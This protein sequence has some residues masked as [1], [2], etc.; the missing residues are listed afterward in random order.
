MKP[1]TLYKRRDNGKRRRAIKNW[2][3]I[4]GNKACFYNVT[5]KPKFADCFRYLWI[6]ICGAIAPQ[7]NIYIN[8]IGLAKIFIRQQQ[9]WNILMVS[10]NSDKK[11]KWF[12]YAIFVLKRLYYTI[13]MTSLKSLGNS[14]INDANLI[15][16]QW[17]FFNNLLARMC[18]NRKNFLRSFY[19]GVKNNVISESPKMRSLYF[20]PGKF[21]WGHIVYG[22]YKFSCKKK[23]NI[24][25]RKMHNICFM[26]FKLTP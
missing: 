11:N 4:F 6:R 23:R 20:M 3:L 16:C 9:I 18:G 1:K 25:I 19:R 26:L 22:R 12:L 13:I 14:V 7:N 17:I 10:P 5:L 24:K 21:P 8:G 2:Q 15:F